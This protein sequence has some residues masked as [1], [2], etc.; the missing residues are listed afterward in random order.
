MPAAVTHADMR[1]IGVCV[2]TD[3]AGPAAAGLLLRDRG[4]V[5]EKYSAHI[6]HTLNDN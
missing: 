1:V 3:F 4:W 2:T 6:V 5:C